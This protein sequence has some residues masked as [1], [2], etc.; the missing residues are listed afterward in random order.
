MSTPI[1]TGSNEL[2]TL[3]T[4][5]DNLI[6]RA[7]GTQFAE[8]S[9]LTA[10]FICDDPR[11]YV[12]P[13]GQSFTSLAKL[14]TE[15]HSLKFE[16]DEVDANVI[17][18][19]VDP[20]DVGI[21]NRGLLIRTSHGNILWDLICYLDEDAV[22]HINDLGGLSAIVVS[23][24]HF[25]TTWADWS[26][27]FQNI[28]VYLA[29]PDQEWVSRKTVGNVQFLTEIH[30]TIVPGVTA[31]IC[32]GHFPGSMA[33]HTDASS[34]KV[35]SLFHADTI[36]TVPNALSPDVASP[37]KHAKGHTS[38]TFMWSIPNAIPLDPDQI[39]QIWRALKGHSIE[40]TYG[41]VTVRS[42]D[43]DAT[44]PQ[45]ILESAKVCVRRMG[46]SDHDIL[47]ETA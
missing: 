32:G 36:H 10:C 15:G 33:L 9:G 11:Q 42:K 30:T 24:P 28:P 7:C 2:G 27:T 40:A 8:T 46:Y 29:T 25:Y 13:G 5:D 17:S 41:F 39:L 1:H 4:S 43:G 45:R 21:P 44:I 19:K 6:C 34:T 16:Q 35:S 31:I 20:P 23:H 18:I 22:K 12:P 26:R 14:R 38:Y 3:S 47:R 37:K